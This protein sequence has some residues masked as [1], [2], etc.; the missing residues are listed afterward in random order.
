MK[1][2]LLIGLSWL[3]SITAMAGGGGTPPAYEV[4]TVFSSTRNA[5]SIYVAG[6]KLNSYDVVQDGAGNVWIGGSYD[7]NNNN[8]Y[9]AMVAA[10]N[11]TSGAPLTS[12]NTTGVYYHNQ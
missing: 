12:Y 3:G 2:E 9:K 11:G 8:F 1:R 4:D 5:R 7:D 6:N 10:F